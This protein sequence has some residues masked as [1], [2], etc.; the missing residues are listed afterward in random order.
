MVVA[1]R[2]RT[3]KSMTGIHGRVQ[4]VISNLLNKDP[5]QRPSN[6]VEVMEMLQ[7]IAASMTGTWF[8]P[9]VTGSLGAVTSSAPTELLAPPHPTHGLL[10]G[11]S[12]TATRTLGMVSTTH[13]IST[14]TL[15][16]A[17]AAM[18]VLG[19]SAAWMMVPKPSE[20]QPASLQ[21]ATGGVDS[22]S[23][24]APLALPVVPSARDAR[25]PPHT[26][27][28][29]SPHP[30]QPVGSPSSAAP[31]NATATLAQPVAS[32]PS[33][34][35]VTVRINSMPNNATV[36]ING[37]VVGKTPVRQVMKAG[38]TAVDV[39]VRLEGFFPVRKTITPNRNQT[40]DVPL[41]LNDREIME[42]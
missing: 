24:P 4:D 8:G 12:P 27:I 35:T 6:A 42:R 23:L 22:P 18:V 37:K 29:S 5:A 39:L 19:G 26:S 9:A 33:M 31:Q 40:L 30:A 28:Q 1:S 10:G 34:R 13:P 20:E 16:K 11:G 7:A 2:R 15:V 3:L 17:M 36:L 14:S 41:T 32:N 21:T 38:E 25:E